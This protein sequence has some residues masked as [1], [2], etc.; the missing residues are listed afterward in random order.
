VVEVRALD[1]ALLRESWGGRLT[2][3]T[4]AVAEPADCGRIAV[5]WSR[6]H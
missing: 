4:L 1:D 6:A 3:L 2:R 5:R